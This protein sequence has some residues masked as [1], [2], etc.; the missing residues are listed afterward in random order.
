[1]HAS[2]LGRDGKTCGVLCP[3]GEP[4]VMLLALACSGAR[5][6]AGL[7]ISAGVGLHSSVGLGHPFSFSCIKC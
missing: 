5:C 6:R 7:D 4:E 3:R 1:M 2:G